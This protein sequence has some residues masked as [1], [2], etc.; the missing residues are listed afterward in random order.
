MDDDESFLS[1][2]LVACLLRV[3][4]FVT[5]KPAKEEAA[6][7]QGEQPEERPPVV[8]ELSL[9]VFLVQSEKLS[10]AAACQMFGQLYVA[11]V[12]WNGVF[13]TNHT[14]V[15][16]GTWV[17]FEASWLAGWLGRRMCFSLGTDRCMVETL[18]I[19]IVPDGHYS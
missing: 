3:F 15:Y 17:S 14:H 2:N 8:A 5:L 13:K 1:L 18:I 6:A 16:I 10:A 12:H 11:N 9:Q 19:V 4:V 7:A